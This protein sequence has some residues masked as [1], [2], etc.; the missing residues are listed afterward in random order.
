MFRDVPLLAII[1][2]HIMTDFTI[3][4]LSP[5]NIIGIDY[6]FYLVTGL[7]ISFAMSYSA[8]S[9]RPLAASKIVDRVLIYISSLPTPR[10]YVRLSF[11]SSSILI[12]I[13]ASTILIPL[14]YLIY[15]Y[16]H[17]GDDA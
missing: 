14:Y 15:L 13:V 17:A 12:F 6:L 10:I 1:F 4:S 2:I 16:I 9:I 8:V 11:I 3:L 7:I 5:S